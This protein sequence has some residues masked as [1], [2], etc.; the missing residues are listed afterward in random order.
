VASGS[1]SQILKG[2]IGSPEQTCGSAGCHHRP[3]RPRPRQSRPSRGG[4]DGVTMR[5]D[6][7]GN[8]LIVVY[9][10]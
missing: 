9:D 6:T 5:V 7:N 2:V 3:R 1:V 4:G 10:T 8:E